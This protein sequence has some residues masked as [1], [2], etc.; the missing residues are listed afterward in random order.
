MNRILSRFISITAALCLG[1][2][3]LGG[4][5]TPA[6]AAFYATKTLPILPY[7]GMYYV[8]GHGGTGLTVDLDENG[9]VFAV[10]YAYGADGK[11]DSI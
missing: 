11:P 3:L 7:R 8:L 2:A 6:K 9:F 4:S 10:F 5:A 1:V